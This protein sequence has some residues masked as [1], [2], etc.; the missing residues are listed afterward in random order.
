MTHIQKACRLNNCA[1]FSCLRSFDFIRIIISFIV[2]MGRFHRFIRIVIFIFW[3]KLFVLKMRIIIIYYIHKSSL[4]L[5][6]RYFAIS[7]YIREKN[8]CKC[9]K[10][11][12]IPLVPDTFPS[13]CT[14]FLQ[15]LYQRSPLVQLPD[16]VY[17]L[18]DVSCMD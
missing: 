7:S 5:R 11:L 6:I 15:C 16:K 9:V 13:P 14:L 8:M 10:I 18:D 4:C 12:D 2:P 1:F 3:L 17:T